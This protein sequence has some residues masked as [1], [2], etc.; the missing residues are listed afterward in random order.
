M[1]QQPPAAE[2]GP[3]SMTESSSPNGMGAPPDFEKLLPAFAKLCTV[4]AELRGPNGCPWDREQTLASIKPY[5]LEET[6]ELLEAIDSGDDRAIVDELGD[7]LLQVVLDCQ[8][9]QDESRFGLQDVVETITAKMIRRH[10][11][12]FGDVDTQDQAEIS[13]NWERI[14]QAEKPRD[15]LLDGIPKELPQLARAARI[16]RK[17]A[18]VGYDF[19]QREMLFDKLQEEVAELCRELF[20]DAQIPQTKATVDATITP[21]A[22]VTDAARKDRMEDEL[23]DVLF[24][25]A[26]IA[27]RWGI[28]PEEALRRSNQ[29]FTRRFQYIEQQVA[30]NGQDLQ[31]MS[32]QDM[33]DLYQEGKRQEAIQQEDTTGGLRPPLA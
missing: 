33:E 15:S 29:K 21:D 10:P 7:V 22:P 27:R 19:P 14:K 4:I 11:H 5:T 32:L 23:G 3:Q 24:V 1:T 28:N 6:Y 9:G 20:D 16:S 12:V 2:D 13:R 17:A 18:K 25:V 26:N 31:Q 30:A 8:I